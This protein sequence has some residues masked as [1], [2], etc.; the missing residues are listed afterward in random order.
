[1]MMVNIK[2]KEPMSSPRISVIIPSYNHAKYIRQCI[3]SALAQTF[4]SFEIIVID[5][6]SADDSIK[7]LTL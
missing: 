6:H 2:H 1:M 4:Q 7:I 3:D 5:D